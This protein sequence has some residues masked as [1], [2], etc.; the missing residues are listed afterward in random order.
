MKPHV[1]E[2]VK[3]FPK[4]LTSEGNNSPDNNKGNVWIPSCTENTKK[5]AITSAAHRKMIELKCK[6]MK[7]V[8]IRIFLS[9]LQGY[10]NY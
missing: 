4:A 2:R 9:T 3:P 8:E 6:K 10:P 1:A 7:L 5:Q